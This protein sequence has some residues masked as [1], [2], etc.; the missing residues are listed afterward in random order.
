MSVSLQSYSDLVRKKIALVQ[1]DVEPQFLP[2]LREIRSG[3]QFCMDLIHS[4]M[5]AMLLAG[6]VPS[7]PG[8]SQVFEQS[9]QALVANIRKHQR[10]SFWHYTLVCVITSLAYA[11]MLQKG[12]HKSISLNEQSTWDSPD[13]KVA[14][15]FFNYVAGQ[16]YPKALPDII[17]LNGLDTM[18]TRNES[19]THRYDFFCKFLLRQIALVTGEKKE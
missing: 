18:F 17:K 9:Y 16:L 3:S 8:L 6:G 1:H 19:T 14:I 10:W 2:N 13:E 7:H 4:R 15:L 12:E 11:E 5:P